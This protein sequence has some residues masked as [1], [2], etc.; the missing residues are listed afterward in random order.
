MELN[1]VNMIINISLIIEIVL[2]FV[3]FDSRGFEDEVDLSIGALG[4]TAVRFIAL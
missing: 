1:E 2:L 4:D 3:V